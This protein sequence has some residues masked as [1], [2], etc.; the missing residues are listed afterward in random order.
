MDR[1]VTDQ[2]LQRGLVEAALRIGGLALLLAWC[3]VIVRPF[4]AIIVWALVLAVAVEPVHAGLQRR[5]G[6]SAKAASGLLLLVGLAVFAVPVGLLVDSV[7]KEVQT[8]DVRIGSGELGDRLQELWS[9]DAEGDR[10]QWA[11]L[12]RN[13]GERL[14]KGVAGAGLAALQL[15]AAAAVAAYLLAAPRT[16]PNLIQRVARRFLGD[17]GDEFVSLATATTQSVARGILG[18]AVIE[19]LVAGVG[20]L[21]IGVPGAGLWALAVLFCAVVQV[22]APLAM[23]PAVIWLFSQGDTARGVIG[24]VLVVAVAI[25]DNVLKPVLLGRGVKVPLAVMLVG[26]LGGT[27]TMGIIGLF[28]GPIVLVIGYSLMV[29]WLAPVEVTDRSA[30]ADPPPAP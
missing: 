16:T 5:L 18:V 12:V 19:G 14:L 20:F 9:A 30:S 1:P 25:V 24:I 13:V 15:L 27:I 17:R 3:F 28:V 10:A 22:P 26:A 7:L 4:L 23:L 21:A 2:S 6:G 29:A 8:L 11:P